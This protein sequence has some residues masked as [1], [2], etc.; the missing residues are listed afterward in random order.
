QV[1]AAADAVGPDPVAALAA[2]DA[3]GERQEQLRLVAAGRGML[4]NPEAQPP[5]AGEARVG[6]GRLVRFAHVG[7][8]LPA[9][10]ASPVIV[11]RR[12]KKERRALT[13]PPPGPPPPP[14]P[15]P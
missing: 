4:L 8:P 14:S 1:G 7:A 12:G 2:Q 11:R 3:A 6:L 10:R 13:P 5:A 15:S 9:R